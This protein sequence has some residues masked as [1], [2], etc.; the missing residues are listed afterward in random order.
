MTVNVI[1]LD[2]GPIPG[3]VTLHYIQHA[4]RECSSPG[5]PRWSLESVHPYQCGAASAPKLLGLLLDEYGDDWAAGGIERY[6]QSNLKPKAAHGGLT[7]RQEHELTVVAQAHGVHLG[8]L[9]AATVKT[10]ASDRRMGKSGVWP[11]S[12]AKLV[13]AR[14]AGQVALYHAVLSGG[15][16][17]PL[18]RA[19]RER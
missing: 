16:P 14:S 5:G 15:I 9:P 13:H 3:I 6:V 8:C 4:P 1:G 10:W 2:P 12:P 11:G 19:W 18:S 7:A 17:D